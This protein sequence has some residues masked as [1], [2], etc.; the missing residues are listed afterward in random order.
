[1]K[2]RTSR[3][4]LRIAFIGAGNVCAVLGRI[5]VENHHQV[6][7]VVSRGMPSARRA[8]R[9]IGCRNVS[10]SLAAIP[11][12]VEVIYLTTPHGAVADAARALAREGRF[13]FKK[14]AVCHASG[15]LTAAVLEPLARRGATTFSFHP[16]QTFPRDFTPRRILPTARGIS[17]GV[18]GPPGG[19]RAAKRLAAALDGNVVRIRPDRRELYH[20]ACVVASNHLTTVLWVLETLAIACGMDRRTARRAFIPIVDTTLRNVRSSSPAEALSGPIARGGVETVSR[21]LESVREHSPETLAYFRDISRETVRLAER[22]GTLTAA[23]R[24]QFRQLLDAFT[25][26]DGTPS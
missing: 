9:F 16:L 15:M 7:A 22:K 21:H 1:M 10:T 3:H 25:P 20:A 5:L 23:Q 18:D 14:I 24:E 8:G 26:S 12:D 13:S 6:V 4:H 2:T 11:P 19:F 17:Y